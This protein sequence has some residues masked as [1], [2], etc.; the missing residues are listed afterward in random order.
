MDVF[1]EMNSPAEDKSANENSIADDEAI[2]SQDEGAAIQ[3]YSGEALYFDDD[4]E[5][6]YKARR[7]R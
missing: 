4:D 1:A 3:G 2:E 7:R 5:D 6:P